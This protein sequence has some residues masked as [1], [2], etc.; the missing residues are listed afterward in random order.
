[1]FVSVW[2]QPVQMCGSDTFIA[3]LKCKLALLERPFSFPHNR[4]QPDWFRR[5]A[6][7]PVLQYRRLIYPNLVFSCICPILPYSSNICDDIWKADKC[8]LSEKKN[9]MWSTFFR[10]SQSSYYCLLDGEQIFSWL[11]TVM[12]MVNLTTISKW[13]EWTDGLIEKN[14]WNIWNIIGTF[15]LLQRPRWTIRQWNYL[16]PATNAKAEK[17]Y[18]QKQIK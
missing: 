2:E 7:S 5:N 9:Q 3:T 6:V 13:Q 16:S 11:Y 18:Y 10:R 8:V 17:I 12:E 14:A 4:C 1:M 15:Y